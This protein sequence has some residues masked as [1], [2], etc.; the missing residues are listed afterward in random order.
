MWYTIVLHQVIGMIYNCIIT[1]S[2]RF[3]LTKKRTNTNWDVKL[4]PERVNTS[5]HKITIN[6]LI[7]YSAFIHINFQMH[8]TNNYRADIW[9]TYIDRP[10]QRLT[11]L[12]YINNAPS[13]RD[14]PHNIG[15]TP[16]TLYDRCAWVLLTYGLTSLSE[17]TQRT[18][19]L[20]M[21]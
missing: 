19:H 2:N 20:L 13:R 4:P 3:S 14:R 18:N 8:F 10:L 21:L 15:I 7:L 12:F 16:P 1:I 17:K 6:A 5:N 9:E 11:N